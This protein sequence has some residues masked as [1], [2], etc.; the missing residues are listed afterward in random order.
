MCHIMGCDL[1]EC[2]SAWLRSA[3]PESGTASPRW[4]R[5]LRSSPRHPQRH[6]RGGQRHDGANSPLTQRQYPTS[7]VRRRCPCGSPAHGAPMWMPPMGCG[8]T[9]RHGVGTS[10]LRHHCCVSRG[11]SSAR[12]LTR[13]MGTRVP[14]GCS[15]H[16]R[17]HPSGVRSARP[18]WSPQRA[19]APGIAIPSLQAAEPAQTGAADGQRQCEPRPRIPRLSAH[20]VRRSPL[21]SVFHAKPPPS[22]DISGPHDTA[23]SERR[24]WSA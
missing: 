4:K 18:R 20:G 11:T 15:D 8:P 3:P 7:S 17:A 24:L 10:R 22:I 9:P 23:R 2:V 21:A 5:A 6:P 12:R 14:S 13:A 1:Q 16:T 19:S